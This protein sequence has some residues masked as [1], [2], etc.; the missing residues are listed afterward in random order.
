M[1]TAL[2]TP[3][4]EEFYQNLSQWLK[5]KN[6]KVELSGNEDIYTNQLPFDYQYPYSLSDELID[7]YEDTDAADR[8]DYYQED[9]SVLWQHQ[10]NEAKNYKSHSSFQHDDSSQHFLPHSPQSG[11]LQS[12]VRMLSAPFRSES[13]AKIKDAFIR[14]KDYLMM[15]VQDYQQKIRSNMNTKLETVHPNSSISDHYHS[16][17]EFSDIRNCTMLHT[18]RQADKLTHRNSQCEQIKN[19][20]EDIHSNI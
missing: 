4:Q 11:P 13:R 12:K 1:C 6:L 7:F 17:Q 20:I 5:V 3:L 9:S 16:Q 19:E 14:G 10:L 2:H 18:E 8:L 15:K